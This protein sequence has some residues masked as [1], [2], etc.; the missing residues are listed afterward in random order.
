MFESIITNQAGRIAALE[1][2]TPEEMQRII[3]EDLRDESEGVDTEEKI[4]WEIAAVQEKSAK[5]KDAAP[6][7]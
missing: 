7:T 5:K 1:N 4:S 2:P 3:V 6:E